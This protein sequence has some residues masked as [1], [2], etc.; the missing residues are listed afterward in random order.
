[1]LITDW[2]AVEEEVTKIKDLGVEV[3][4]CKEN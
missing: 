2:E 1:V 4:V 3:I